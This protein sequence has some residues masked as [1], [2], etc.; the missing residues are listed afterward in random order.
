MYFKA[1][2]KFICIWYLLHM[3]FFNIQ[4]SGMAIIMDANR[5]LPLD[6]N[7]TFSGLQTFYGV[8]SASNKNNNVVSFYMTNTMLT[9]RGSFPM[10][11]IE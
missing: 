3:V 2:I 8:V 4:V 6:T 11:N 7:F 5:T 10:Y 1:F 9:N